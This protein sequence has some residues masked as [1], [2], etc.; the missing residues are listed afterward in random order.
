MV[1]GDP[2]RERLALNH[3][4]LWHGEHKARDTEE[5]CESL[6]RVR[7]LLF[8]GQ[9]AEATQLAND[10]FG[11]NGGVSGRPGRVMP[12][13]PAGDL[14]FQ[15]DHGP[16]EGYSRELDLDKALVTIGYTAGGTKIT[17][18]IL[19]HLTEDR[20]LM[21]IWAEGG[22]VG[23]R[24]TLRRVPDPKASVQVQVTNQGLLLEG[25]LGGDVQFSVEALVQNTIRGRYNLEIWT[26]DRGPNP[27]P[28]RR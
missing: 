18:Q 1:M 7:Q 21:R 6:H 3:E 25:T 10:A 4:W 27:I 23:G 26:A 14:F 22:T 9:Y 2:E 17:R 28:C 12:Y 8:A 11:G 5:N 19:A 24:F 13:Q 16:V 20:I 15:P